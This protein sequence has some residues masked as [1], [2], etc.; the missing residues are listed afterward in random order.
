VPD[1]IYLNVIIQKFF[2]ISFI[3]HI[4]GGNSRMG[5]V[6]GFFLSIPRNYQF[7][8]RNAFSAEFLCNPVRVLQANLDGVLR[9]AAPDEIKRSAIGTNSS[10]CV[11]HTQAKVTGYVKRWGIY[12]IGITA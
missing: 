9:R 11:D 4:Y 7:V 5:E 8:S 10:I 2:S 12:E 6:S 3:A 1:G